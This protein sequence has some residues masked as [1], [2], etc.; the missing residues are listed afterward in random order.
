MDFI[1][2]EGWKPIR[3]VRL[4]EADYDFVYQGLRDV[5][6]VGDWADRMPDYD[7]VGRAEEMIY[8]MTP[9]RLEALSPEAHVKFVEDFG[10]LGV[11]ELLLEHPADGRICTAA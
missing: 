4:V 8:E 2:C 11:P 7:A 5:F 1:A 6:V 3:P 10:F 9:S